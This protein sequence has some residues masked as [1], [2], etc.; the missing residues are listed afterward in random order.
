MS[1]KLSKRA[2][3]ATFLCVAVNSNNKWVRS[4][5]PRIRHSPKKN[6]VKLLLW[7]LDRT[8]LSFHARNVRDAAIRTIPMVTSNRINRRHFEK[9]PVT[10]VSKDLVPACWEAKSVKLRCPMPRGVHG[11]P[12]RV[13]ICVM[14]VVLMIR[15]WR[16]W[17]D[18]WQRGP[19]WIN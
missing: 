3:A 6:S 5:L 9:L 14:W 17:F 19:R 1:R 12:M 7:K 10:N 8:Q 13:C 18:G 16:D 11:L 15:H 2:L 4:N